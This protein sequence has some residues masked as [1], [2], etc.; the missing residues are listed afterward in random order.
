M[1]FAA[2]FFALKRYR[3]VPLVLLFSIVAEIGTAV[4]GYGSGTLSGMTGA[5]L[6]VAYQLPMHIL[7]FAALFALSRKTG[8]FRLEGLTGARGASPFMAAAFGFAMFSIMGF[9]PFKGAISRSSVLYGVVETGNLTAV[10]IAL[11]ATAVGLWYTL[12]I[13]Q[14]ICFGKAKEEA[15]P[16]GGVS[17]FAVIVALL[18][19]IVALAH[20]LPEGLVHSMEHWAAGGG[21][22]GVMPHF[23]SP[24][25]LA[26]TIPYV[27]GFF[28]LAFARFG[29]KRFEGLPVLEVGAAVLSCVSFALVL[30]GDA[31]PLSKLFAGIM[32]GIGLVIYVY[33][34]GYMRGHANA[35]RY[36]FFLMLMQGSLVGLCLARDLG[37]M[38]AF[39]ELMTFSSYFLVIHEE[40]A[41]ALRAGFKYFIMC[42]S[43][44]YGLLL[45]MLVLHS[46]A[47]TFE[48]VSLAQASLSIGPGVAAVIMLGCFAAFAVKA[49]LVPV[50]GWLPEAHPVAPSSISAPLSGILTKTGVYGIALVAFSIFGAQAFDDGAMAQVGSLI[51]MLGAAT[52]IFAEVMALR[53][54]NVKRML[55]YSTMAQVGE[56]IAVLGLGTYLSVAGSMAHVVN[57]AVMKNL[58]F[59]GVGVLIMRAGTY[60]ISEL[61]GMG[62]AM[63]ITGMCMLAGL[64]A[65]MGLPPFG[66]F[67]SKF[68]MIYA[69]I[70]AGYGMLAAAILG[71]GLV[72]VLYYMRL[73]RV[74][75]FEKYEGPAVEEAPVACL[76]PM[77]ALAIASLVMG[78][79]PQAC[80]ALVAPVA[81]SLVE[82]GKL[83]AGMLP[84]LAVSWPA[85]AVIPMVGAVVPFALRD[86]M[87]KS[88][89]GAVGVLA[90]A[91]IAVCLS[92]G[93]IDTMSFCYAILVV[94]MG[95]INTVY[96][97]SYMD[98]SHTQ[99]RFFAFLLLMIGGLL[100]VAGSANLFTFFLFWEIMSSWTLYSVIVH[101]E[102]PGALREGYKYFLFNVLGATFMFFGVV[103]MASSAG[104]FEIEAVSKVM[105]QMPG[106][107]G[108]TSMACIA[109]GF[110]MKAA[111]L[112]FRIDIWMH[113]STA[114]TPVSG[115]ISSVLLKSGPFGLMKLFF[116]IGGTGFFMGKSGY[117]AQPEIMYALAWVGGITIVFA[118]L[119][120]VFQSGL[121][122]MLI[123]S[124][125]SHMGYIVLGI[126]IGTSLAVSAGLMHFANHMFF[127]NLVFLAAGAIM[128]RTHADTLDQLSGIGRKMP[129][130]LGVFTIA[131][132]SAIGL[133]P[134]N[135]FTSK[136]MLYH[137]LMAEGEVL[138]AI[139]SLGGSVLTMAYFIKFLHAAFFG[140][141]N[142]KYDNVTEVPLVMRAPMMILAA[143]CVI[144][145]VF[146]G[147][148]LEPVNSIIAQTGFAP[149]EV[150]ITGV[151]SGA[152]AWNATATGVLM[153][154]AY[155]AARGILFVM[156]RNER[157]SDIHTCGVNDI[158]A[159]R[160]NVGASGLYEP[161]FTVLRQWLAIPANLLANRR[162]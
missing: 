124:T 48:Y 74:L 149:L 131:A 100:G 11:V 27:G 67:A 16:A 24:W 32:A 17:P 60:S 136:W 1:L 2:H 153:L 65:I 56:I 34:A 47:G 82:A 80:L 81:D 78:I 156:N 79:N 138:L 87:E 139:L 115:Y 106:W 12:K 68:L 104:T 133:P 123:Y 57:H 88:A 29:A 145:G 73:V 89:W 63:P 90:V 66:G 140:Q 4:M 72:G 19:A 142:P 86:N 76:V 42:A 59:L 54:T 152:G 121:K 51:P 30:S 128:Y 71:G 22:Q 108:A 6:H 157:V 31:A 9:N 39:W 161:A 134:L 116:F 92:Y 41:D 64:L 3:N 127:K 44:A 46:Q 160:L 103:L 21:A 125:V 151:V 8:S 147:L 15:K 94:M 98:H 154:L 49:G 158:C 109:L 118:S 107:V 43:G 112:P 36:W 99:W 28:L 25:P 91:F 155:A 52:L 117:W 40:T 141:P 113:P 10:V 95:I 105:G 35:G 162:G 122:R 38:Y 45:G 20:A 33:S 5:A 62:R 84:D 70:D 55:A 77:A 132:F 120:A 102:T 130:T 83:S 144:F 135:G 58:L 26:A 96:S 126:S 69:C 119:M 18:A 137:G 53:Q 23:E 97:V 114:P 101:E 75:F 148:L 14:P 93:S 146:P 150:G 143:G 159:E 85:F 50:H 13:V 111:M 37:S 7:A 61:K 110:A 129:V